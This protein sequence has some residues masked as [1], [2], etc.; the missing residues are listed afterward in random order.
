MGHTRLLLEVA[1]SGTV[2][3]VREPDHSFAGEPQLTSFTDG[4]MTLAWGGHSAV[5]ALASERPARSAQDSVRAELRGRLLAIR[6]P[7]HPLEQ[8]EA[9]EGRT[10]PRDHGRLPRPRVRNATGGTR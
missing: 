3:L 6:L 5:N 1:I 8:I 9:F 7:L 2:F 10:L 4:R